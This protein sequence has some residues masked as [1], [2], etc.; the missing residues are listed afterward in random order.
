[1]SVRIGSIGK[2]GIGFGFDAAFQAPNGER[3]NVE[4]RT[5]EASS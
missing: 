4:D 3:S 2:P 1:M 5:K